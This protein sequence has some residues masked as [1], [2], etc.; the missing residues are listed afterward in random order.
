[1]PS[2]RR[3]LFATGE[4]S[5]SALIY[6]PEFA[7]SRRFPAPQTPCTRIS[8][9]RSFHPPPLPST[10]IPLLPSFVTINKLNEKIPP[11]VRGISLRSIDRSMERNGCEKCVRKECQKVRSGLIFLNSNNKNTTDPLLE[12]GGYNFPF[13]CLLAND[14]SISRITFVLRNFQRRIFRSIQVI[15]SPPSRREISFVYSRRKIR[16]IH[17]EIDEEKE[18]KIYIYVVSLIHGVVLAIGSNVK[19]VQTGRLD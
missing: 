17:L 12:R 2:S 9:Q 10:F 3:A 18:R 14:R 1:M 16:V 6:R 7:A 5:L 15:S 4:S 13:P 19:P 8:L 11:P